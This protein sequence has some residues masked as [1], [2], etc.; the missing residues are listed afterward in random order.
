MLWVTFKYFDNHVLTMSQ[1]TVSEQVKAELQHIKKT[2][3]HL[4]IDGTI[5]A[6]FT[7]ADLKHMDEVRNNELHC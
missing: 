4:T 7:I 6:R 1:V 2:E 5:R 3:G